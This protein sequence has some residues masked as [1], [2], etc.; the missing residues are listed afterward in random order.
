MREHGSIQ[1][2]LLPKQIVE[3]LNEAQAIREATSR[4]IKI[5]DAKYSK[6]NLETVIQH[7]IIYPKA[8]KPS[9]INYLKIMNHYLMVLLELG[10][11]DQFP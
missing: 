11:A 3:S 4:I 9:F 7:M 8:S 2:P 6:A 10:I 5:L 1:N